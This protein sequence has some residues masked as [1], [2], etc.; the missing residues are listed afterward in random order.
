MSQYRWAMGAVLSAIL[1][2]TA[3]RAGPPEFTVTNLVADQSG[4]AAHLDKHLINAWG[5]AFAPGDFFWVNDNGTGL[6]TLYDGTGKANSLVVK[7]PLPHA[8]RKDIGKVSAPTGMVFNPTSDFVTDDWTSLF[9]FDSEDGTITSWF[10]EGGTRAVI[11]VDHSQTGTV[12]CPGLKCQGAVYKG[13]ALTMDGNGNRLFAT[14][15][16]SGS[17]EVYDGNFSPASSTGTFTDPNIPTGYAPYNIQ[18]VDGQLFVTYAKQDSAKHDSVSGAGFGFVDIFDS[19]GNFVERFASQGVLNAPWGVAK[20]PDGFGPY[21]GDILVGNFGDGRIHVFSPTGTFLGPL[22]NT[23]GKPI[24]I[25]GLWALTFGGAKKA[26]A[27]TLYFSA[28]PKGESHGLFGSI[29]AK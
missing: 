7:I 27:T 14:N 22:I 3:A 21:G 19:E 28:G 9:I 11:A 1:S 4:H 8:K 25:D 13:L 16:R 17:I 10:P 15:F 29:A 23:K 2:T 20:A 26:P 5:I 12:N 6:S 24:S 18:N